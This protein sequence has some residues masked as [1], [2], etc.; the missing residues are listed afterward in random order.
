MGPWKIANGIG[1]NQT[2]QGLPDMMNGL[3]HWRID[4]MIADDA[5]S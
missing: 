1:V 3:N 5:T 4:I 2:F